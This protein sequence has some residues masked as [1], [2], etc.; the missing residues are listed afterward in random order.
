MNVVLDL[1][2]RDL[3]NA[4]LVWSLLAV[5]AVVAIGALTLYTRQP[6]PQPVAPAPE[7]LEQQALLAAHAQALVRKAREATVAAERA[8]A[9]ARRRREE[10]LAAQDVAETAWQRYDEADSEARRKLTAAAL[11][12]PRTPQTPA[13]YAFRERHLHRSAMSA[14][15]HQQLSALELSDALAHRAGWDPRRHPIEQ[16]TMLSQFARASLRTA[17]RRAADTEKQA[18]LATEAATAAAASL[19][20]AAHAANVRARRVTRRVTTPPTDVTLADLI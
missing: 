14:C 11:P 17:Y 12:L 1:F 8:A 5:L 20:A 2:L 19:R 15:S 10:W 18:W 7:V 3:P 16:E 9:T 13:E 6:E 4:A